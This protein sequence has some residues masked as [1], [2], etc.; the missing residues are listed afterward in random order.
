MLYIGT[1]GYS[2]ADWLG[3]VYPQGTRKTDFL[4]HYQTLFKTTELNF[5]Y[6]RIPTAATLAKMAASVESGFLF[7]V[8]APRE[9]THSDHGTESQ[10]AISA[11]LA[12]LR[13]L[14][15]QQK[16]ACVLLQFPSS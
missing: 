10:T 2:Y 9:V 3:P 13:P 16:F 14:K 7:S 5:T 6:Y 11:F 4:N 1:S 15:D 12:A 8:K